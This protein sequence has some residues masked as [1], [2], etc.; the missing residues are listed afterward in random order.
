[1]RSA[2]KSKQS[3]IS[4][5]SVSSH[6][7]FEMPFIGDEMSGKQI[8]FTAPLDI[9]QVQLQNKLRKLARIIESQVS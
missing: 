5:C 1:M 9:H 7:N 6:S 2:H 3:G 4:G 8:F